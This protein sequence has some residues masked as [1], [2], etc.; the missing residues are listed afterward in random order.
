MEVI[1]V[2]ET[3][4]GFAE[5]GISPQSLRTPPRSVTRR[6][7]FIEPP[8]NAPVKPRRMTAM[9]NAYLAYDKEN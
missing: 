5:K 6:P 7:N 4:M 2:I 3:D 1:G 9:M 8:P